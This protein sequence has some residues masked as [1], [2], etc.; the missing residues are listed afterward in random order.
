MRAQLS[1]TPLPYVVCSL[2]SLA[3]APL[4]Q[5]RLLLFFSR[6]V[7]ISTLHLHVA[8]PA[9]ALLSSDD[10]RSCRN[11]LFACLEFLTQDRWMVGAHD[12]WPSVVTV[13]ISVTF[14]RILW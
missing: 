11:P 9:P 4:L 7:M 2:L 14:N 5:S 8:E 12:E 1:Y 3:R 6:F 13:L 10:T